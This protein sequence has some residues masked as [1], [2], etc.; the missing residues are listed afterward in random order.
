M[1]NLADLIGAKCEY[2]DDDDSLAVVDMSIEF[3]DG[4]PIPVYVDRLGGKLRFFDGG[5]VVYHM[6][7]RH[8]KLDEPS[9]TDFITRLT[10]PEGV[11]LNDDGELELWADLASAR[12]A[13]MHFVS[14]M[15]T[16][17]AWDATATERV[18]VLGKRLQIVLEQG[19]TGL[20]IRPR[21]T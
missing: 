2:L 12:T 7:R 13:L 11:T 1:S 21:R 17:V 20:A 14:A 3:A 18:T 19:Q 8:V 10:E 6:L 15:L 4:D 16:V 5:D 9:D